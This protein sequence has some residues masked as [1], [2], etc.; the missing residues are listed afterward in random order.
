MDLAILRFDLRSG[1]VAEETFL[2]G[3]WPVRD[4]EFLVLTTIPLPE[5]AGAM[6]IAFYEKGKAD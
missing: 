6:P 3:E 4:S 5:A 2:E 1:Y